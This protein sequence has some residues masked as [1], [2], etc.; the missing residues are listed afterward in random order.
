MRLGWPI[1]A[2][3]IAEVGLFVTAALM[4]G[5]LG[6]VPLAAHGIAMQLASIAFMIPLGL[7]NAAT[8]RVGLEFGRGAR[9]DLRAG[10]G[11]DGGA[12]DG[13]RAD[14]A[15]AVFWTWPERLVGLFLDPANPNA[16]AVLAY[17]VPLL[18]V[19]AAFQTVDSLQ[20]VGSG[21]LRGVQDTRV[22]MLLALFSYWG[23]RAAGGLALGF[24]RRL[25][26]DR[27]L[28]RPGAR[29]RGRGAAAQRPL[30]APRPPRAPRPL[31]ALRRVGS[32]ADRA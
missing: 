13:H 29:P 24:W 18:L 16:P 20:A 4:M 32:C 1:G 6:T 12:G 22:P 14:R 25:G 2:T 27:H 3:I 17:A 30:R 7:G 23:G 26:R 11:D 9:A 19:A 10:G 5:W 31:R 21:L 8:V 28:D 15:R